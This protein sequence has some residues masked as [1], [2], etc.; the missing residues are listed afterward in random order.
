M[1]VL[2][3]DKHRGQGA[4]AD[5]MD[6]GASDN[7]DE[8]DEADDG[9]ATDE[10]AMDNPDA[11][12]DERDD[13]TDDDEEKEPPLPQRTGATLWDCV[14]RNPVG[15]LQNSLLRC[16]DDDTAGGRV[17]RKMWSHRIYQASGE[18][19]KCA[20]R[21]GGFIYLRFQVVL[22]SLPFA[23][24]HL[25]L[26]MEQ[27]RYEDARNL[28]MIFLRTPFCCM[29][30]MMSR[31]I[32]DWIRNAVRPRGDE[33][34][35]RFGYAE[36]W[37][38]STAALEAVLDLLPMIRSWAQS[39]RVATKL[40]EILHKVNRN[41]ALP[42]R[43]GMHCGIYTIADRFTL[44]VA[45]EIFLQFL[46]MQKVPSLRRRALDIFAK[47]KAFQGTVAANPL[48]EYI[49][50]S[51]HAWSQHMPP[52]LRG[53]DARYAQQ[54][55]AR[56]A[57][58]E[59]EDEARQDFDA[60]WREAKRTQNLQKKAH[61]HAQAT[62]TERAAQR[63]LCPCELGEPCV[64]GTAVGLWG[65]SCPRWP[66][67]TTRVQ[68]GTLNGK[69]GGV[70]KHARETH[71]DAE[72]LLHVP[73]SVKRDEIDRH[74]LC[75]ELHPGICRSDPHFSAKHAI[76]SYIHAIRPKDDDAPA[77]VV[78]FIP[79]ADCDATWTQFWI[80]CCD[81]RR[82]PEVAVWARMTCTDDAAVCR[83]IVILCLKGGGEAHCSVRLNE[84]DGQGLGVYSTCFEMADIL[85][86]STCKYQLHRIEYQDT[87]DGRRLDCTFTSFLFTHAE[88]CAEE[89][90][91]GAN[92]KLRANAS[93]K[94]ESVEEVQALVKHMKKT[95]NA[96][97]RSEIDVKYKLRLAAATNR[98]TAKP[99][100]KPNPKP[101]PKRQP[102]GPTASGP[103]VPTSRPQ[104]ATKAQ[105][106]KAAKTWEEDTSSD[107][108]SSGTDSQ[109][110]EASAEEEEAETTCT[111]S[112]DSDEDELEE[113]EK[114]AVRFAKKE[115]QGA[116]NV[117]EQ[118]QEEAEVL[119]TGVSVVDDGG[120]S[121]GKSKADVPQQHQQEQQD[122]GVRDG[123]NAGKRKQQ[124]PKSRI[125][126]RGEPCDDPLAVAET[127]L[128]IEDDEPLI[129]LKSL[130]FRWHQSGPLPRLHFP[131][132]SVVECSMANDWDTHTMPLS[133][134]E[135]QVDTAAQC[136]KCR[137]RVKDAIQEAKAAAAAP[138]TK[139][140][141]R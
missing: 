33:N 128:G 18:L 15:V 9:D 64:S 131:T 106:K 65:I 138:Q 75:T 57:Y 55:D 20:L 130:P 8:D 39:V 66:C 109:A 141:R 12:D 16:M 52:E 102:K 91:S 51:L 120:C 76:G 133:A 37:Q 36:S 31:K 24:V 23:L 56:Q 28:A 124:K 45:T 121:S 97:F 112:D 73:N 85:F 135:R 13:A 108:S 48:Y 88:L 43:D 105:R 110:E 87:D 34:Q 2:M 59:M 123:A 68:A 84:P 30:V 125:A 50:Q 129:I 69:R 93:K 89:L 32:Y 27:E 134:V 70:V 19:R 99:Q 90:V 137:R 136:T 100:P 21:A 115:L 139:K 82:K 118:V 62:V 114:T 86:T 113:D 140:R 7:E 63:V 6:G 92:K 5:A 26:A 119:P 80:W 61:K 95:S 116:I 47:P 103:D 71:E 53:S 14:S 122:N 46:K 104:A 101:K 29:D 127:L 77:P 83:A 98:P 40:V 49:N 4:H 58:T 117:D 94:D 3:R 54:R 11:T 132:C 17:M 35:E 38:H 1:G 25:A 42:K 22:Q 74:D 60:A 41:N 81:R 79:E 126:L 111:D 107:D 10:A 44:S 96:R 78:A 72:R 67:S